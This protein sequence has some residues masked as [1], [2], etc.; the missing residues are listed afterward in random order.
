VKINMEKESVTL[1][2]HIEK[3]L[4]E[5]EKAYNQRFESQ[6]K[7]ITTA[8]HARDVAI[9]KAEDSIEKK[10]DAVYVKLSD[11]AKAMEE[12]MRRPEIESRLRSLTEKVEDLKGSRDTSTGKGLGLSQGLVLLISL[13]GLISSFGGIIIMIVK[14]NAK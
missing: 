1:K 12:V 13:V 9:K 14:F 4:E 3:I 10:S 2:E 5:K 6:E 8:E 7:A 11:L